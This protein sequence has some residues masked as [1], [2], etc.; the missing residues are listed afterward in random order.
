MYQIKKNIIQICLSKQYLPTE[1]LRTVYLA[2]IQSVLQYGIIGWG[3]SGTS[4][5]TPLILIQKRIIKICLKKPIEYPT[6]LIF[7]EFNVMTVEQIYKLTLL[8]YFQ[9]Y[10]NVHVSDPHNYNTRRNKTLP[11]IEPKYST[12]SGSKHSIY[13]GPRLYNSII[14]SH[15]EIVHMNNKKFNKFIKNLISQFKSY[16]NL[17]LVDN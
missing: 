6:E 1:V 7:P 11:L 16:F 17:Y 14:R 12:S 10:R 5:L 4:V 13:Y 15:P 3:G 2:L 8:K 9:K